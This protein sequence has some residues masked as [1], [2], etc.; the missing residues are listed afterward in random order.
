SLDRQTL[1]LRPGTPVVLY[2]HT[3]DDPLAKGVV[4]RFSRGRIAVAIRGSDLDAVEGEAG[5]RL[6]REAPEATFERGEKAIRIWEG[7]TP[8][9]ALETMREVCFGEGPVGP[10]LERQS[11]TRETLLDGA[12]NASQREAVEFAL[13]TTPIA[14]I[15][16]PPG[17]G[18]TRT[19]VALI[20]EAVARGDRVLACAASNIAVDNMAER[21]AAAGVPI[22]RMG[23]PERV[24]PSVEALTLDVLV[25]ATEGAQLARRWIAEAHAIRRRMFARSDRGRLDYHDRREM[26]ATAGKLFRDARGQ[27]AAARDQVLARAAVVCTTAYGAGT[28]A[29]ADIAFDWVVLDEATQATDPM[30]MVALGRAPRAVLAGDPMQLPPTVLDHAAEAGALG[31]TIFERLM[32]RLGQETTRML[33]VQYRMHATLMGLVNA[34]LY[35]GRLMAHEGVAS[36]L[37]SDLPGIVP[38]AGRPEPLCFLDTAGRGWTEF[39]PEDDPSVSNPDQ[40][41]RTALEVRRL[42]SR[43]VEPSEIAVI[44]PYDAQVR[45]LRGRLADLLDVGLEVGSVDGFQGREKRVIVVDLVRSNERGDIGFLRDVRRINVALTR[46]R[47]Q[48]IVLGD[49]ATLGGHPFYAGCVAEAE[50]VG[51]WV[52]AW[53]DDAEPFESLAP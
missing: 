2:R 44:T 8:R 37:L 49:G 46:A 15:H 34:A 43:G 29:I 20:R 7:A 21:L 38:D 6:D 3:P 23:H 42:V 32:A 51:G 9:T 35:G 4:G 1:R 18:K 27:L 48:L 25:D 41:A 52:S 33:T 24:L 13:S 16:G 10:D 17:T 14:L 40:G 50:R 53:A 36:A 45:Q 22:V 30:A 12:L 5:I 26:M 28:R 47:R 11:T 39:R 19:L 31:E